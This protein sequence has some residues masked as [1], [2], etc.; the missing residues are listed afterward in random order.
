MV[1]KKTVKVL[2]A[3]MVTVLIMLSGCGG[4]GSHGGAPAIVDGVVYFGSENSYLYAVDIQTGQE[5][6]RVSVSDGFAA[7]PAIADGVVYF[8]AGGGTLVGLDLHTGREVWKF[9]ASQ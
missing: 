4:N 5:R 1:M 8:G 2:A 3:A 7:S 9:D 6:W